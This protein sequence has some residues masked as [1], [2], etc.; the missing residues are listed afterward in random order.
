MNLKL[1]FAN[2]L[3]MLILVS[4]NRVTLI[5]KKLLIHSLLENI[6]LCSLT[7]ILIQIFP[8]ISEV[9]WGFAYFDFPWKLKGFFVAI[10]AW[11]AGIWLIISVAVIYMQSQAKL[12]NKE[13]LPSRLNELWNRADN[14]NDIL[15]YF[16]LR[17]K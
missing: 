8:K 12:L 9:R 11:M 6:P 1:G 16:G 4:K 5:M 10:L 13:Q 14:E 7:Y 15:G 17:P 3:K 2:V